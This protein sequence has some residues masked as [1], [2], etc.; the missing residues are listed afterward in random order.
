MSDNDVDKNSR[1]Y[2][3]AEFWS[4]IESTAKEAIEAHPEDNPHDRVR[5]E[6]FVDESIS[7]GCHY[8]DN[9]QGMDDTLEFSSEDHDEDEVVERWSG[10]G[11]W[12]QLKSET[13]F[14]VLRRTIYQQ[15]IDDVDELDSEYNDFWTDW[16]EKQENNLNEA[17]AL[18]K[19]LDFEMN[20][21]VKDVPTLEE[22][23]K[24]HREEWNK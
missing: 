9:Y 1:E 13:A 8:V 21:E 7:G 24:T 11:G 4:F 6:D 18:S 16:D 12:Q 15:M 10:K 14:I 23:I 17:K 3:L 20:Y 5:R 19:T 2:R 22:F